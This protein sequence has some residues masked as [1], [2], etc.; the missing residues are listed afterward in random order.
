[1]FVYSFPY[2]PLED[3]SLRVPVTRAR[4]RTLDIT[5]L[6]A[7]DISVGPYPGLRVRICLQ[8]HL[9]PST[10]TEKVWVLV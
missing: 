10:G 6:R 1:M 9:Y 3:L 7:I 4:T 5:N 8:L 2:K